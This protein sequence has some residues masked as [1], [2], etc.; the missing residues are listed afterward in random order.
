M[1]LLESPCAVSRVESPTAVGAPASAL[2]SIRR[3]A[4][5][6][7]AGDVLLVTSLGFLSRGLNALAVG[8]GTDVNESCVAAATLVA[9]GASG[10]V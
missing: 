6:E 2:A 10:G 7:L 5:P 8:R 9:A 1:P 3:T 4:G